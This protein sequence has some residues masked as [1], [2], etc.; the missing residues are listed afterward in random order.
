MV[1]S[2]YTRYL[3]QIWYTHPEKQTTIMTE[4]VNFTYYEN[5]RCSGCHIEFRKMSVS[6]D[7]RNI[8]PPNLVDKCITAMAMIAYTP[9]TVSTTG[10]WLSAYIQGGPN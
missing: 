6:P 9:I 2:D 8:F 10:R 3:N 4:R 1:L 5:S 7:W